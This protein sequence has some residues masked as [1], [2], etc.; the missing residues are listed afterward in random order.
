MN[1]GYESMTKLQFSKSKVEYASHQ[2]SLWY[3]KCPH[4]CRYCY[5]EH[6]YGEAGRK[7]AWAVGQPRLN[8]RVFDLAEH[9]PAEEVKCL[10]ISFTNDCLPRGVSY[11]LFELGRLL[12]ILIKRKIPTRILTK[13][14]DIQDL[15]SQVHPSPYLTVGCSITTN[16]DN[17]KIAS[18][19]EPNASTITQRLGALQHLYAL[20]YQTW[21]SAE[22]ILPG[23]NIELLCHE[24]SLVR[25]QDIW[26][27]KGN[28]FK[29]LDEAFD[30]TA[31]MTDLR[32]FADSYQL[33]FHY[34]EE[35]LQYE[36]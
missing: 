31:V 19:W 16:S 18:D 30:W 24:L 22:P 28:Y 3:G 5:V 11:N 9:A 23:T 1:V 29:E 2:L 34:K 12:R 35:L 27:G 10:Y 7:Y 13:N 36:Y 21:I 25:A 6:L 8:K 4:N 17:Q 33:P 20:G 14:A 26:I 32:F 15:N